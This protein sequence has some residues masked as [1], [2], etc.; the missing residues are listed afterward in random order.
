M[1]IIQLLN[2]S[3]ILL[4]VKAKSKKDVLMELITKL[5]RAGKLLNKERFTK[6][7]F[8]REEISTTGMGKGIA[9]PHAKSAGVR[10]T[11][12]AF[13]RSLSGIDFDS[14]DGKPAHLFFMIA[15]NEGAGQAHLNAIAKLASYLR[16]GDFKRKMM[17]AVSVEDILRVVADKERE[18]NEGS[19]NK[20]NEAEAN[21]YS[22]K[23]I[24]AVTACPAGIAHT[25]IAAEKLM[26]RAKDLGIS[27][28]VETNG[29][30]GVK[31]RFT[32][33]DIAEAAAII[34]AADKK[35]EMDR[36][37]GKPVI[38]TNVR[39]AVYETDELLSR[40]I[41]NNVPIYHMDSATKERTKL[42]S[43]LY[44]HLMNGV[45]AVLPFAVA[46]GVLSAISQF[47][48]GEEGNSDSLSF[49]AF[50]EVI[51][52]FGETNTF[53]LLVPILA[54]FIASS[55]ADRPG[56][57]PGMIGGLIAAFH[58][59]GEGSGSGILG[60]MIA[61]FLAGYVTLFLKKLLS[62][63]PQAL[64]GLKT[65]FF[66][67]VFSIAITGLIMLY[68]N[69]PLAYLFT[70]ISLFLQKL[71][72]VNPILLGIILGVLMAI[73]MGGPINKI[74]YTLGLAMLETQ[75]FSYMAVIMAT[76]MVP[77]M[78]LSLAAA[79]F[80]NRFNRQER[81]AGR[82]AFILGTCFITEG[83]IPFVAYDRVRVTISSMT[84]AA[85]AGALTLLFEISLRIPHGGV[86]VMW[87]VDGGVDKIL[88]YALAIL[89]GTVMT[90]VMA[91]ILKKE[92]HRLS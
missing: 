4:D 58:T 3:T 70:I 11:T 87:L 92:N 69:F 53:F 55:L 28:K 5:D 51:R 1:K 84:G 47:W 76:G 73:D 88:L 83:V 30:I 42:D 68:I 26:Q 32:D 79:I 38:Q 60:G 15:V 77:P 52:T 31:N 65:V 20:A 67:P 90:A 62:R 82:R 18:M 80:R 14:L 85:A 37:N 24:L 27:L 17:E 10:E 2:E 74:V 43:K 49:H 63:I 21:A 64:D 41:S 22:A 12:I 6:D 71:V 34:V 46:G 72:I 8:V 9:I 45:S 7:I 50:T 16:D 29:A 89:I 40:A 61:G 23:K 56:F 35:V 59:A 57:A 91:G 48:G 36:F 25:Y 78:G 13:G 44:K 75:N 86:F 33:R 54:A 19:E 81:A 66:L 39:K